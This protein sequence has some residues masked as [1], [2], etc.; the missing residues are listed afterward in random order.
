M[1]K[2]LFFVII[3]YILFRLLRT[4]FGSNRELK[5]TREGGVIDEMVQDPYCETYIPKRESV[6]RVVG[7]E[8]HFFCSRE[9]ADKF[10]AERKTQKNA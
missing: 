9:C 7:G 2:L 3:G 4:V 8:Q 10:E 1:I 6:K 5:R